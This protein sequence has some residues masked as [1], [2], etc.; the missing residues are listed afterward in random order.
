MLVGN[1][2]AI[3]FDYDGK[4]NLHFFP[5][6]SNSR[7][8]PVNHHRMRKSD[9]QFIDNL[10]FTYRAGYFE[11]LEIGRKKFAYQMIGVEISPYPSSRSAGH[12]EQH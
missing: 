9:D 10:I 8:H 6:G 4:R 5:G 11:H 7:Q 2:A 3:E 12:A 1:L